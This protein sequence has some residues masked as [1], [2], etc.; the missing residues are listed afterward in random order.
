MSEEKR[1]TRGRKRTLT[2]SA[3]K[4]HRSLDVSKYNQGRIAL[5]EQY[6]RWME[7]KETLQLKSHADVA[8]YLLDRNSDLSG[9]EEFNR[10]DKIQKTL[11]SFLNP[12]D[13]SICWTENFTS[14]SEDSSDEEHE[15]SYIMTIRED[16][17]TEVMIEESEDEEGFDEES[18][19]FDVQPGP[20]VSKILSQEDVEDAKE[21]QP[22]IVYLS[23]IL[24]LAKM[25]NLQNCQIKSCNKQVSVEKAIVGVMFKF[26]KYSRKA[27]LLKNLPYYHDHNLIF[28]MCINLKCSRNVKLSKLC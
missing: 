4:R 24:T 13:L 2:D 27:K 25:H 1:S 12:S 14:E 10:I 20:G 11:K 28:I 7:L 16:T 15:P 3:R 22:F 26:L 8:E 23:Q 17:Q 5:G 18:F 9:V 21:D 19:D 6:D